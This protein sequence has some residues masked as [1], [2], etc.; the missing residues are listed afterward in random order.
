MEWCNIKLACELFYYNEQARS[1]W[2]NHIQIVEGYFCTLHF[3]RCFVIKFCV[4]CKMGNALMMICVV[5]T[6]YLLGMGY[7]NIFGK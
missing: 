4:G 5:L 6:I 7:S 1:G 3:L 2:Y